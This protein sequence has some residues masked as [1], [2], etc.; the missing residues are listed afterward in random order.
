MK[1]SKYITD[2]ESKVLQ[3]KTKVSNEKEPKQQIQ[4][5]VI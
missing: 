4:E 5:D 1:W 3:I 2:S